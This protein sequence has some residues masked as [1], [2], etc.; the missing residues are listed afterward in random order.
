MNL[1]DKQNYGQYDPN[2]QVDKQS[3]EEDIDAPPFDNSFSGEGESRNQ[4][5][6]ELQDT[7]SNEEDFDTDDDGLD[8]SNLKEEGDLDDE[9]S[10]EEE[11]NERYRDNKFSSES[12]QS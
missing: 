11:Q 5:F 7:L 12:N 9:D 4:E 3:Q 6:D 8:D 2:F 1:E 10:T